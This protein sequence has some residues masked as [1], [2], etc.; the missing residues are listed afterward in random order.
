MINLFNAETDEAL[1]SITEMDLE[2]LIDSLEET[3]PEDT[4]YYIDAGTID[5][6]SEGGRATDHLLSVLRKALGARD[7]VDVRWQ[8][9]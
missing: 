3:S 4:D 9:A 1:G 6:I 7:G 5:L 8:K 2:L